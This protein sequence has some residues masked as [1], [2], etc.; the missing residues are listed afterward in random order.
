MRW[1]NR[2]QC[3]EKAETVGEADIGKEAS[4]TKDARGR[5]HFIL[6]FFLSCSLGSSGSASE[7]SGSY[8]CQHSP[9]HQSI[10]SSSG[11]NTKAIDK[12]M[13]QGFFFQGQ[14]TQRGRQ[15]EVVTPLSST[16]GWHSPVHC[17]DAQRGLNWRL[18][19]VTRP[20]R[21]AQGETDRPAPLAHNEPGWCHDQPACSHSR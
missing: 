9:N 6:F 10:G 21:Q 8:D 4:A 16:S 5:Q 13:K 7:D 19:C 15:C 17:P 11:K 20:V 14:Q 1:C 2:S 18:R 12:Q 3:V